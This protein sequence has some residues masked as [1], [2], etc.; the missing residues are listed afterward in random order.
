MKKYISS[1][2]M[3][4][5]NVDE[6]NNANLVLSPDCELVCGL[7]INFIFKIKLNT[8]VTT[9]TTLFSVETNKCLKYFTSPISGKI[10]YINTLYETKPEL[11]FQNVILVSLKLEK[12]LDLERI[13]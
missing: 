9:E 2:K 10:T 8:V 7:I 11:L 1:D 12:E 4:F 13:F 3:F 5:I 6:T